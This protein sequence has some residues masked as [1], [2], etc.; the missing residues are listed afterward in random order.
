MRKRFRREAMALSK[1]N[2]PNIATIHDFNTENDVDFLAMEYISGVTLQEKA[3]SGALPEAEAVQLVRQAA[4]ALGA[5]HEQ[6]LIHRDLKPGNIMVT[7]R[8]LVKVLDFGLAKLLQPS[9]PLDKTLTLT[10]PATQALTGTLPYMAPEQLEGR[11]VDE[12]TD[13]HALGAILYKLATGKRPYPQEN[14]SEVMYAILH[15]PPAPPKSLGAHISEGLERIIFKCLE[16]DPADRYSSAKELIGDLDKLEAGDLSALVAGKPGRRARRS[17]WLRPL[18]V[19]G[20]LSLAILGSLFS[21]NIGGMR[22][23][24]SGRA[25]ASGVQSLAVLPLK[26]L[27]QDAEQEYLADGIT[28]SL[29][30]ELGQ[31]STL[32][33]TSSTS[34]SRYKQTEESLPQIAKELKVD[35]IVEGSVLRSGEKVRITAKLIHP[36]DERQLWAKTFERNIGDFLVLQSEIAQDI[37]RQI[38]VRLSEETKLQLAKRRTVNPQAMDA[39][40]KGVYSGDVEKFDQAVKID[41][42]FALAYTKIAA[43]YFYSGLFGDIPPRE[44]FLKMKEAALKALEKDGT[45]GEAHGYLAVAWLH[46]DLN[47]TEA[48][49][50]FKRAFELNPSLAMIHHLYA[51]YLMAMNRTGESMAEINLAE[52]LD[53]FSWDR[54]QCFG[55]HCLFTKGYDEAIEQARKG[56]QLDPKNAWAHV[57]LGWSYEQK[58][59]IKEAVGEFQSALSQWKDNSLPLAGLGHA[60]AISGHEKEAQE[61]LGK[62]LAMSKERYVPAYDIA[63]VYMGLGENAQAFE[64][65]SKALEE[66]S[67]FLVYIK[68]DRRFDGLRSDP[69]YE[70][71]IK[72]I[73]LPLP[74]ITT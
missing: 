10:G 2:H 52:E 36:A 46:Y 1:L 70:A 37:T 35:L 33:V 54:S 19:T 63:V 5:A 34:V 59:M 43:A 49:K 55:W 12:R 73:G 51:H 31:I 41:P 58:F 69:R 24:L 8:G 23:L 13:I 9:G 38:G 11:E 44:A 74:A 68:C 4:E 16:K 27:S 67:G 39:Y 50:E 65:L 56:V 40:F 18:P 48:E 15:N 26:S 22:D 7:P 72:R 71:L 21:L 14:P 29:I 62:L 47:W 60:D 61:I 32:Q 57:I 64:W 17:L 66:R 6:G 53:P 42:D 20:I 30:S 25:K 28:D 3:Q 45:L